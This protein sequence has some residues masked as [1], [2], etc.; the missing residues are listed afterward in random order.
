MAP[1]QHASGCDMK[2]ASRDSS[3]GV[4]LRAACV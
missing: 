3:L 4:E 1:W 2:D